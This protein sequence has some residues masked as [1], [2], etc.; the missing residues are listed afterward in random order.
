MFRYFLTLEPINSNSTYYEHRFKQPL[1]SIPEDES[2]EEESD[3]E[4]EESDE[5]ESEL[6]RP[7]TSC[8]TTTVSFGMFL[9]CS[10]SS[11]LESNR[12]SIEVGLMWSFDIL[13]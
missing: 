12:F 13:T 10:R 2:E 9:R 7:S 8:G 1:K 11:S 5:E 6:E 3:D 4:S